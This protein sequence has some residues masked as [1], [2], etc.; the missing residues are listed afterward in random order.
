MLVDRFMSKAIASEI[1]KSHYNLANR[2]SA[3]GFSDN[4]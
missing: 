2:K 4:T 1:K 3:F